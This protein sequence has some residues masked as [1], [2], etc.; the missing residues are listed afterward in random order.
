MEAPTIQQLQERLHAAQ[1]AARRLRS[2]AFVPYAPAVAGEC[3]RPIT[4]DSYNLLVAWE[5]AYVCGG[6]RDFTALFQFIWA[7]HPAFGQFATVERQRVLRRVVR[8]LQPRHPVLSAWAAVLCPLSRLAR[9]CLGRFIEAPAAA[10]E[11]AADEEVCRLVAEAIGE[12]PTDRKGAPGEPLPFALQAQILG[13][14]AREFAMPFQVTR[15]L[16]LKE[17]SQHLREAAWVASK[18]RAMLLTPDEAAVW[19]DYEAAHEKKP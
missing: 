14:M 17:L 18:G 16:P 7:H 11:S 13:L 12:F 5:N 15:A 2:Q 8:A 4:L 19:H 6:P 10:L 9:F 3:L 1:A